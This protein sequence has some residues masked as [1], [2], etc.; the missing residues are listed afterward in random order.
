MQLH[1]TRLTVFVHE[2]VLR[3]RILHQ[4]PD[5][6]RS[7]KR[8][9]QTDRHIPQAQSFSPTKLAVEPKDERSR[10]ARVNVTVGAIML[11]VA[12]LLGAG[13][14]L[15]WP[16]TSGPAPGKPTIVGF[17]FSVDTP[18]IRGAV[19]I[20]VNP[21]AKVYTG[22][23]PGL[24]DVGVDLNVPAGK[25]VRWALE[26]YGV[27]T[28]ISLN[29]M[30]MPKSAHPGDF[31]KAPASYNL[32]P[33]I[34]RVRDYLLAGEVQGPSSAYSQLASRNF[35]PG[36]S[37]TTSTTSISWDGPLPA[38]FQGSYVTASMPS[39][40]VVQTA[41]P[42]GPG[43][44]Y[45]WTP[46]APQKFHAVEKLALGNDYQIDSGSQSSDGFGDWAWSSDTGTGIINGYGIG[47][48]V[49]KQADVQRSSFVAGILV[50][51]AASALF[52]AVPFLVVAFGEKR[53]P[54]I[55]GRRARWFGGSAD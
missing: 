9:N 5:R 12:V 55:T 36:E 41:S 11:A 47:S 4:F 45:G 39:L 28:E 53:L 43:F 48:S 1:R 25:T 26:F 32:P 23:P 40:T 37:K 31:F 27:S 24:M 10:I 38:I 17:S 3:I 18:S 7:P 35:L 14:V 49:T 30:R 29:K 20:L 2:I 50:G 33:P 52:A 21:D 46:V 44:N 22:G 16:D 8:Q 42:S 13:A 51:L 34:N 19:S 6:N 15:L 54:K